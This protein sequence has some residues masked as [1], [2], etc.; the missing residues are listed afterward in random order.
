[1]T[2]TFS[3]NEKIKALIVRG[4]IAKG[5][6]DEYSDVDFLL[7]A[8][9]ECFFEIVVNLKKYFPNDIRLLTDKGWIDTNVPNFGGIG[10]VYLVKFEGVLMQ[11]D[12]Y[13]LPEE[14]AEKIVTFKDKKFLILKKPLNYGKRLNLDSHRYSD[15]I[16]KLIGKHPD[17]FQLFFDVLLHF[18]MLSKYICRENVFLAYKYWYLLNSKIILFIR[19]IL[20]PETKDFLF[21][22]VSRQLEKYHFKEL[23]EFEKHLKTIAGLFDYGSLM[24]LFKMFTKLMKKH[25]SQLYKENLGLIREVKSYMVE[26][27]ETRQASLRNAPK[28]AI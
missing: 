12:V 18:E 13:L 8:K 4:S 5:L 17:D 3:E 9:N 27:Y 25:Y 7:I 2:E 20:E 15:K 1:M 24:A 19:T 10:F 21:Y 28:G 22:D 14:N 16:N 26:I 6:S 11:L 23:Y